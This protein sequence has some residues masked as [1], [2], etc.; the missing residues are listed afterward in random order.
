VNK[1]GQAMQQFKTLTT[2]MVTV[3]I[4]LSMVPAWAQNQ[5]DAVYL[6]DLR[7]IAL[8]GRAVDERGIDKQ[9]PNP[10][11]QKHFLTGTATLSN[12]KFEHSISIGNAF[13]HNVPTSAIFLNDGRFDYF[14]TTVGIDDRYVHKRSSVRPRTFIFIVIGDNKELTRVVNM[15]A[16]DKP[17]PLRIPIRNI[18]RLELAF[19]G[20]SRD[21]IGEVWWGDARF[22]RGNAT[23]NVPHR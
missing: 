22:V 14:E 18:T 8:M 19:L 1:K 16:G 11:M 4:L 5:F 21:A 10:L 6:A 20:S 12:Q 13:Y 7:P 9:S 2:G 3:S 15:K 23:S 17:V